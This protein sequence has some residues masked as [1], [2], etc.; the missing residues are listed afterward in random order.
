M[1]QTIF[2][3]RRFCYMFVHKSLSWQVVSACAIPV[4]LY[5]TPVIFPGL[6]NKDFTSIKKCLR[7]LSSSSDV[8]YLLTC[9]FLISQH[10]NSCKRLSS[11][12]INDPLHPLHACLANACSTS[13]SC[14]SIVRLLVNP[15]QDFDLLSSKIARD[16]SYLNI[17]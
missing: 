2:F 11:Y 16:L 5:Y 7:L 15:T 17:C 9:K 12:I 6:L 8:A 14:P 10:F 3:I 1:H 13:N 4:T